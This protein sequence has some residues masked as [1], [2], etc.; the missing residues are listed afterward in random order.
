MKRMHGTT[1]GG[2]LCLILAGILLTPSMSMA[3]KGRKLPAT[4]YIS[5]VKIEVSAARS[6]QGKEK[7]ERLAY[8]EAMVDSCL[9][10]YAP[11]PAAYFWKTD[12]YLTRYNEAPSLAKK[13]EFLKVILL[14]ADS[15]DLACAN[16][17]LKEAIRKDCGILTTSLDSTREV[18]WRELREEARKQT[19]RV[20]TLI[21]DIAKEGGNATVD[22]SY[23]AELKSRRDA[24]ADSAKANFEMAILIDNE[25][26]DAYV[27]L[28]S[29]MN[30][31]GKPEE[32]TSF[33][34]EALSR[35]TGDK[36]KPLLYNLAYMY[37]QQ[38]DFCNAGPHFREYWLL[39]TT[40]LEV[41]QNLAVCY[42]NCKQGDSA[43]A[44]YRRI[45]ASSP[46]N[47][48]SFS[49]IGAHFVG[50]AREKQIA[51]SKAR[52]EKNAADE[53][54]LLS[55]RDAARDS[56]RVYLKKYSDAR[57]DD[58]AAAYEYGL[59]AYASNKVDEAITA[60]EKTLTL[61]PKHADALI[62][63]GDLYQG[64]AKFNEAIGLYE[65]A[66]DVQPDNRAIMET[67][68]VLY[69]DLGKIDKL[70]ALQKKMK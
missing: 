17:A 8:A 32:A 1:V 28:G 12:I 19:L 18:S 54:R 37:A 38:N 34:K 60:M 15:L 36:R 50:L 39:D 43:V 5:T 55:E 4:S 40:D 9:M 58:T 61:D 14:Y 29:L 41:A 27:G 26:S 51:I 59:M 22:S 42:I 45:L 49:G 25:K 21:E 63:L 48:E 52:D 23:L 44:L 3:Q 24:T 46:D 66:L 69:S 11:Y 35:S 6:K 20:D 68:K 65:R 16:T 47:V 57:P 31:I 62:T 70:N 2:I 33:T 53:K 67:L 56:A 30:S 10:H 13:S 7:Q 64:K